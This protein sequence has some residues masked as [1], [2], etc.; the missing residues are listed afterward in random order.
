MRKFK[1]LYARGPSRNWTMDVDYMLVDVEINGF[2]IE[3]YAEAYIDIENE[4]GTYD[5]LK[6][7]ILRQA[8]KQEIDTESLIFAYD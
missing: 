5:C 1:V 7:E 3:L 2:W 4:V 8:E 6:E